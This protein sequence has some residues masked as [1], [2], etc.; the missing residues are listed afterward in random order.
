MTERVRAVEEQFEQSSEAEGVSAHAASQYAKLAPGEFEAIGVCDQ[1]KDAIWAKDLHRYDRVEFNELEAAL[2]EHREALTTA[3]DRQPI[4]ARLANAVPGAIAE[5][6]RIIEEERLRP[7]V[8]LPEEEVEEAIRWLE[9]AASATERLHHAARDDEARSLQ[10]KVDR[11]AEAPHAGS[12]RGPTVRASMAGNV[13]LVPI[14]ALDRSLHVRVSINQAT[15]QLYVKKKEV[16]AE[17][18]PVDVFRD[19][20]T[21]TLLLANGHHRVA[22]DEAL[23]REYVEAVVREGDRRAAQLFAI[24]QD[25]NLPRTNE[26][27]RKAVELLLADEEWAKRS[28]REIAAQGGVHHSTVARIRASKDVEAPVRIGRDGKAR[29]VPSRAPES[30][31]ATGEMR[32]LRGDPS[33]EPAGARQQTEEA[34]PMLEESS[35]RTLLMR[36]GSLHRPSDAS[37]DGAGG[38]PVDER[39]AEP[40]WSVEFRKAQRLADETMAVAQSAKL[41]LPFD[42][43]HKRKSASEVLDRLAQVSTLIEFD[44]LSSGDGDS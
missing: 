34:P 17:F 4:Y 41:M 38:E 16:G 7:L 26:D 23:H 9:S 13:E 44:I 25:R 20:D 22:A 28:D 27:K 32:Q 30:G 1:I 42:A 43:P 8:I 31:T 15:V 10:T 35:S 33:E 14:A 24:V 19:P 21:G 29:K 3:V 6:Q 40:S 39:Q 36:S 18:P 2:E 11:A 37:S 12:S 5:A